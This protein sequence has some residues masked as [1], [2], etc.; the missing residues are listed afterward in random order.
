MITFMTRKKTQANV[1]SAVPSQLEGL[2][3]VSCA[4]LAQAHHL[5][6]LVKCGWLD[7]IGLLD[8]SFESY[9]L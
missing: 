6:L 4:S 2:S 7:T 5:I 1:K 3:N 8:P 9:N